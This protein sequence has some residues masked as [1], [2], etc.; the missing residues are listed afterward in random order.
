MP[1]SK[2]DPNDP[3]L[4]TDGVYLIIDKDNSKAYVGS[5]GDLFKRST[6]HCT[7][8]KNNIHHNKSLQQAYNE[9]VEFEFVTVSTPTREEAYKLEQTILDDYIN[10][11]LLLNSAQDVKA[12]MKGRTHSDEAKEKLR[13][14]N[15]GKIIS[16][17]VRAKISATTKGVPKSH[18]F[19]EALRLRNLGK[20]LSENTKDKLRQINLGKTLS[21]ETK[22]KIKQ[23]SHENIDRNR[24]NQPNRISVEVNG[25]TYPSIAVVASSIG[26]SETTVRRKIKN[27]DPA[28]KVK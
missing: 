4:R 20:T 23:K 22:E 12:G 1:I 19:V 15:T 26:L 13:I 10:T 7:E 21:E 18:E 5:T 27:K 11:D 2:L 14:A 6:A 28:F 9:G 16:D 24:E 8:L 25:V 17:E 3:E